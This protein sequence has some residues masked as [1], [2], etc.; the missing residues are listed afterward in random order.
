MS[1]ASN[2]PIAAN[3]ANEADRADVQ[4]CMALAA[5]LSKLCEGQPIEIVLGGFAAL[6]SAILAQAAGGDEA[7]AKGFLADMQGQ[8][9]DMLEPDCANVRETGVAVL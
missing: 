5:R 6:A 2:N 9:R 8:I 4:K 3:D 1:G 7:Q